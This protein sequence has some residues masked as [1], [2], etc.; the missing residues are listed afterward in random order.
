MSFAS[1]PTDIWLTAWMENTDMLGIIVQKLY[2]L[3]LTGYMKRMG[4]M[5]GQ[6]PVL[7][8]IRSLGLMRRI[9]KG[10]ERARNSDLTSGTRTWAQSRK[11]H[12]SFLSLDIHSSWT[13]SLGRLRAISTPQGASRLTYSGSPASLRHPNPF[14]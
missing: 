7:Q 3:Q 4:W 12:C 10:R 1:G 2:V 13:L 6:H 9:V 5:L 8:K 14:R 11:H